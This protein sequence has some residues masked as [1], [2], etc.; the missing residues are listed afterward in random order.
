MG[1]TLIM[2]HNHSTVCLFGWDVCNACQFVADRM[3]DLRVCCYYLC[4][5]EISTKSVRKR[6]QPLGE[7]AHLV[8]PRPKLMRIM[9]RWTF[10]VMCPCALSVIVKHHRIDIL[11]NTHKPASVPFL[12]CLNPNCFELIN[13][14]CPNMKRAKTLIWHH[15]P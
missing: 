3:R 6:F 9:R 12:P 10:Y 7:I 8:M 2:L 5:Q 13:D 1:K 11:Q 15:W 14:L 4:A